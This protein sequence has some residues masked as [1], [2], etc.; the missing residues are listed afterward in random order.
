MCVC[1][2]ARACVTVPSGIAG[3]Y[4]DAVYFFGGAAVLLFMVA[5]PGHIPP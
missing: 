1:V 5:L 2:C 4:G 3:S